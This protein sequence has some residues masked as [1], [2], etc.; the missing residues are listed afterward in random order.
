MP[1]ASVKTSGASFYIVLALLILMV[2][3]SAFMFYF[4]GQKTN[5]YTQLF[6]NYTTLHSSYS[7]ISTALNTTKAELAGKHI[8]L[9]IIL[10]STNLTTPL[11]RKPV[12]AQHTINLPRYNYTYTYSSTG[13]NS[14]TGLLSSFTYNYTVT[15]GRFN[16]SFY[17][18]YPGYLI[19]N[20]TSTLANHPSPSTCLWVVYESNKLGYH[21]VSTTKSLLNNAIYTY[22]YHYPG[23]DG[24]FVNLTSSPFVELCPIQSV[25][26]YIPINKGVNYLLIDNINSTQ[27]ATVTFSAEYVGFHTS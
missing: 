22:I 1:K 13:Y 27:G 15:W 12:F 3:I 20:G 24:L 26:Y 18:P 11:Y 4:L 21:N 17:V 2:I 16:Y 10:Q 7:L 14:S 19:F 9:K 23:L 6:G 8:Y 25:T 5:Q